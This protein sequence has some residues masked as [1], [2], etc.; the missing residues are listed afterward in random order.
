MTIPLLKKP[1]KLL[2]AGVIAA[3]LI[4][5]IGYAAS[6]RSKARVS[7]LIAECQTENTRTTPSKDKDGWEDFGLVCEPE[8]LSGSLPAGDIQSQIVD[9]RHQERAW[10]KNTINLA[11]GILIICAIPYAWYFFLRRVRELRNAVVGK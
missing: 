8:L 1:T 4:V 7:D 10:I 2:L 6:L 11:I 3:L 5:G 9:A